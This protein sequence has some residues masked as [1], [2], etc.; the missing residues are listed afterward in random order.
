MIRVL[1]VDDHQLVRNGFCK[2]LDAASDIEVVGQ[3]E[4]G[5]SAIEKAAELQPD[6]ILMDI[7][8]PGIGGIEATRKILRQHPDT[9]VVILSS[10]EGDPF[11]RQTY[12]AG[13]IGFLS[14][15]CTQD[16]LWEA[17][18]N[19]YQGEAYISGEI[20][21]RLALGRITGE[22]ALDSLSHREMQILMLIVNGAKNKNV[23]AELNLS[24]KTVS[25]HKKRI[26]GKLSVSNDVELTHLAL[27]HNLIDLS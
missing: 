7:Q 24:E 12:N 9:Q 3:A 27:R 11:P 26:Y 1:V 6:I 22:K 15:R 23:A 5:E 21:Q 13:A 16:E 18:R 19:A 17:V 25:T 2:L 4:S 8:M 20:A 10:I 14:K